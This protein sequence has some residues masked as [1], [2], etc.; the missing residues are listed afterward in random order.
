MAV[1]TVHS[2]FGAQ[3]TNMDSEPGKSKWVAKGNLEEM[4]HI[5]YLNF[6]EGTIFLSL[7]LVP[8]S[9]YTYCSLSPL[10]RHFTCFLTFCLCGN[11]FLQSQRARALSLTTYQWLGFG[12]LTAA[13]DLNFWLGTKVLPQATA[14]WS[15]QKSYHGT[16]YYFLNIC[17][18]AESDNYCK[19]QDEVAWDPWARRLI[20]STMQF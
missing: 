1:V 17:G 11:F 8:G 5:S 7:R 18:C 9:I 3:V 16:F 15:H 4:P 20:L 19:F 12:A 2:D 14:G 6:H 13:P 10:N